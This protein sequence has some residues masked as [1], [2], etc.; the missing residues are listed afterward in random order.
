MGMNCKSSVIPGRSQSER[1]RNP[2]TSSEQASGFRVRAHSA[3]KT[4]VNALMG[5]SRNDE[6]VS[7]TG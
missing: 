5:A 3:S 2:E 4:R 1:T 6:G 7:C